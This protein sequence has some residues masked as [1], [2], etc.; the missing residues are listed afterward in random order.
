MEKSRVEADP[1]AA[2]S[3]ISEAVRMAR[4]ADIDKVV[5]SPESTSGAQCEDYLQP[6]S[7]RAR[8]WLVSG[9]HCQHSQRL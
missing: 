3:C 2:M 5:G 8:V 7:S 9:A 4:A 1:A 6:Y